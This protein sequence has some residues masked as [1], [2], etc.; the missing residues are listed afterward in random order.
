M[1]DVSWLLFVVASLALIAVPGQDMILVMSRSI[2]QGSAAGV[3]TAAGVSVGLLGHTVLATLGLGV[4]LRTSELLFVA[5][6]FVW[7]GVSSLSRHRPA[8]N[9]SQQPGGWSRTTACPSQAFSRWRVF[10]P[11]QSK[12]CHLLLC[13]S[14]AVR[15]TVGTASDALAFCARRRVRRAH[16]PGQGAGRHFLRRTVSLVAISSRRHFLGLPSVG[17]SARRTRRETGVRTALNRCGGTHVQ[18]YQDSVQFRTA[19]HRR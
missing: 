11:L 7:R 17:C 2:A 13:L 1:I 10:Q 18:K 9:Q 16:V 15:R 19:R 12:S 8:A 14:S 4:I 3:V 5:L 6:K